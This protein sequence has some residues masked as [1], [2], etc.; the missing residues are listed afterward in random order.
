MQCAS[1][2]DVDAWDSILVRV[3]PFEVILNHA[4]RHLSEL[5]SILG[6]RVGKV[7]EHDYGSTHRQDYVAEYGIDFPVV[8][9]GNSCAC[10]IQRCHQVGHKRIG[11]HEDNHLD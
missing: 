5:Q 11:Q 1:I 10:S 9:I 2:H 3:L 6:V 8:W 4:L 7:K